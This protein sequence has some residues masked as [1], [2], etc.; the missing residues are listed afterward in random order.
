MFKKQAVRGAIDRQ[1]EA[2]QR[3][4]L[5][6]LFFMGVGVVI[7]LAVGAVMYFSPFLKPP[8]A[9]LQKEV[10]VKPAQATT[11]Q[12]YEFYEILPKQE[13]VSIPKGASQQGST[14]PTAT[15]PLRIDTVVT[16]VEEEPV[17]PQNDTQEVVQSEEVVQTTTSKTV[18]I[19]IAKAQPDISYVLQVRSYEE[20]HEAELK[21]GEVMMAGVDAMVVKRDDGNGGVLYTVVSAPMTSRDEAMMAYNRLQTSGIDSVV[22]EQRKK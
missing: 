8:V 21:R 18:S 9:D 17:E 1:A 22:V 19:H 15:K 13:F 10:T 11:T 6:N 3:D 5:K 16:K 14:E 12:K 2:E 7:A 20:S 4:F